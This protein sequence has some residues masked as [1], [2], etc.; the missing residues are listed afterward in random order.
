MNES[1]LI[2]LA[3][4]AGVVVS[5]V[6]NLLIQKTQNSY[7]L[8][9][10]TVLNMTDQL[11]AYYVLESKYIDEVSKLRTQ[12]NEFD[13]TKKLNDNKNTIKSEIR[14][15]AF[16]ETDVIIDYTTKKAAK[17]KRDLNF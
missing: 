12:L 7:R 4:I 11:G 17:V 5:G 6:F 10:K 8:K 2:A 1:L 13:K 9:T 14:N 15:L 3:T 16:E